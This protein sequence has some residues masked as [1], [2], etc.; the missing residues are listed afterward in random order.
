MVNHSNKQTS[1]LF[2]VENFGKKKEESMKVTVGPKKVPKIKDMSLKT[3]NLFVFDK[4]KG[5]E[6]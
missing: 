1:L 5:F 2:F 4:K 6:F 3:S